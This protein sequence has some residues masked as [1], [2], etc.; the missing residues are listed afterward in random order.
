M[1]TC[2][3]KAVYEP[4]QISYAIV[5]FGPTYFATIT[6]EGFT[7][8]RRRPSKNVTPDKMERRWSMNI[9]LVY[10]IFVSISEKNTVSQ[11]MPKDQQTDVE[12][13]PTI[14]KNNNTA[15]VPTGHLRPLGY[16]RKP[17]G[18]VKE[19]EEAP[20]PKKFWED[21][22]SKKRP[23]VLRQA[24]TESPAA[25][26]WD[27]HYLRE[28]YGDVDVLIEKKKENREKQPQRLQFSEFI[29][30]YKVEDRYVV[31]VLPDEMRQDVEVPKCLLCGTFRKY[32]HE[33]NLWMSSGGTASV[34]HYDADHK[35]SLPV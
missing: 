21:H 31:T 30:N 1:R 8:K 14:I 27:D 32:L 20:H 18:K 16:Q 28:N 29:D 5:F 3:C 35:H 26:K 25:L 23:L 22:V 13:P 15:A 6:E 12:F 4:L 10:L 24:L 2:T 34:L 33:C 7:L 17:E 11:P 19:Y 9:L